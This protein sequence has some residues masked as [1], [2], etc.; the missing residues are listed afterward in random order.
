MVGE[1]DTT[2]GI[3]TEAERVRVA[4]KAE[5]SIVKTFLQ[6]HCQEASFADKTLT[7]QIQQLKEVQAEMKKGEKRGGEE[8]EE[9]AK[10]EK[11]AL[12]EGKTLE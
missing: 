7:D 3:T 8:I 4:D 10:T 2:V 9:S 6:E 11:E 12:R 5:A 1:R